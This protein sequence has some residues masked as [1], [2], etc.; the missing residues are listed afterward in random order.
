MLGSAAV[1]RVKQILGFRTNLDQT[2][3]ANL[4]DQQTKLELS[5]T[6]PW[7]LLSDEET[8]ATVASTRTVDL[9][10][11][12]LEEWEEGTITYTDLDGNL[13]ELK[14]DLYDVLLHNYK[15]EPAGPPE[16]YAI[17]GTKLAI[18]PL[19]DDAY[20]LSWRYYAADDQIELAQ[21]NQW[22]KYI[23]ELLIGKAGAF[24]AASLRDKEAI[25]IF[26][27]MTQENMLLLANQNEARGMAN[28]EM[29]MGG[30]Q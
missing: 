3:L 4:R 8:L 23:P 22:L 12:F 2:I 21:E 13:T 18:F 16:A 19:P 17:V 20:T 6:K 1:D 24:V 25:A 29:Q 7:F 10:A 27:R 11:D 28:F 15:E 14:K 5:P 30:P 9:P 26:D